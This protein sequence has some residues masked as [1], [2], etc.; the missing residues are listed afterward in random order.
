VYKNL[1]GCE[2]LGVIFESL[3]FPQGNL[4][5]EHYTPHAK[6]ASKAHTLGRRN[7][8]LSG[9]MNRQVRDDFSGEFDQPNILHNNRIHTGAAQ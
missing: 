6:V 5:S 8:H 3:Q 9:C 7:G 1:K 4:P 2:V